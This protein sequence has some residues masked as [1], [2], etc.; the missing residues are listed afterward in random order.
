MHIIN[1]T[2]LKG[3]NYGKISHSKRLDNGEIIKANVGSNLLDILK[4]GKDLKD[5]V[6]AMVD[7]EIEE[8]TKRYIMMLKFFQ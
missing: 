3:D 5:P 2:L 6:V 1:Y 7:G 4:T 8:L